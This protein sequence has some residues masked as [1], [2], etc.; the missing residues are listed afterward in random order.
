MARNTYYTDE[1]NFWLLNLYDSQHKLDSDVTFRE[2]GDLAK[3]TGV[4]A[5]AHRTARGMAAQISKLV[6]AREQGKCEEDKYEEEPVDLEVSYWKNRAEAT[7]KKLD[8][9]MNA[10][11][12]GADV[13]ENQSGVKP[14]FNW[15]KIYNC[16]QDNFLD[17]LTGWTELFTN[18]EDDDE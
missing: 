15:R 12:W 17:E 14:K 3:A 1:E 9:L 5:E 10:V 16:I 11:L 7:Q 8:K 6:K 18:G 2:L 4:C 13:Y